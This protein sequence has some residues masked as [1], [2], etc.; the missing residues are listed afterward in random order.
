[1]KGNE[2]PLAIPH[3]EQEER[4]TVLKVLESGW[5]AHG[6]YNYKLEEKFAEFIGV[7]HA[8]AMN[9]CTSALE[10]SLKISGITGEVIIP[11]FTFVATANAVVTSRAKPVF[12]DVNIETQM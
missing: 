9:S 10:I 11:S 8:V 5:L 6:E 1:M 4:E 3:I 2:I 7:K 12:C